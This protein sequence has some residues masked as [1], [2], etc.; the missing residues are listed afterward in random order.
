MVQD[1]ASMRVEES[2]QSRR[3]DRV[4]E[5]V[6]HEDRLRDEAR[7]GERDHGRHD[8]HDRQEKR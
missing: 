3:D 6:V 8:R 4:Y 5:Q 1:A 2:I 7:R